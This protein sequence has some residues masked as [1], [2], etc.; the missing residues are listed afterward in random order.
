MSDNNIDIWGMLQNALNVGVSIIHA[1][2]ELIDNSESKGSTDIQLILPENKNMFII[3]DN[4]VGMNKEGLEK[5]GCLH[6]RTESSADRHGRFGFGGKQAQITLTNLEGSV[7]SLSSDELPHDGTRVSQLT[8][9]FLKVKETGKYNFQAHGIESRSQHIWEEHAINRNGTGTII[10]A[11][12]PETNRSKLSDLINSNTFKGLRY[13]L[14]TMYRVQLNA[15]VNISIKLN[16]D[17]ECK[18]FPIDLLCSSVPRDDSDILYKSEF[19]TL[20]I[21]KKKETN[22]IVTRVIVSD[23]RY[24]YLNPSKRLVY[25]CV[26]LLDD[27]TFELIGKVVHQLAYSDNWT[28]LQKHDLERNGISTHSKGQSGIINARLE[29]NAKE[30]ARNDK[31]I[32]S[33]PQETK[34]GGDK[35]AIRYHEETRS[36]IMFTAS[37]MMD[38]IFGVQ[39]NKSM[40]NE[41]TINDNVW[42]TIDRIR[43]RFSTECYTTLQ[44]LQDL[45]NVVDLVERANARRQLGQNFIPRQIPENLCSTEELEQESSDATLLANWKKAASMNKKMNRDVLLYLDENLRGWRQDAI[46]S[47]TPVQSSSSQCS[48]P[49]HNVKATFTKSASA[50][51]ASTSNPGISLSTVVRSHPPSITETETS[52]S[53]SASDNESTTD[54]EVDPAIVAVP[55]EAVE[56]V[57]AMPLF[58]PVVTY[59]VSESERSNLRR[60]KGEEILARWLNSGEHADEF[61]SVLDDLHLAYSGDCAA[62]TLRRYLIICTNSTLKYNLLI[63]LIRER[64]ESPEDHMLKGAELLRRYNL[65][66]GA[67][68]SD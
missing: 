49:A 27:G 23:G 10:V 50:G 8:T 15:G 2:S 61:K 43:N 55:S 63:Q 19:N 46:E 29:T 59:T 18:I 4:G 11:H 14:G 26:P 66:F 67:N 17:T 33:F 24:M 36:R 64:H 44:P 54:Y 12:L 40:V 5:C 3:S 25:G 42:T 6:S 68:E 60:I 30:L 28:E 57:N 65:A 41:H 34:S 53:A 16:G 62:D 22:E 52:D 21:L 45:N 35:A 1:I 58:V 48:T 39:V 7:V 32:M 56:P 47:N 20:E 37:D 9:D 38:E 51:G 13:K 31:V